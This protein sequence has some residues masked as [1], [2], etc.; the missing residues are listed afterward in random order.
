MSKKIVT[1]TVIIN[2]EQAE[3][4]SQFFKRVGFSQVRQ[5]AVD[6]AEAYGMLD[7]FNAVQKALIEV[8]YDPR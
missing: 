4:L 1:L 5:N 6:D 3:A 7:A 8:G 2:D